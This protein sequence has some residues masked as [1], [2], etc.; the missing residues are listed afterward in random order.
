MFYLWEFPNRITGTANRPFLIVCGKFFYDLFCNWLSRSCSQAKDTLVVHLCVDLTC[1]S[2]GLTISLSVTGCW[3]FFAKKYLCLSKKVFAQIGAH[4]SSPETAMASLGL[5]YKC[6][7][8]RIDEFLPV[9]VSVAENYALKVVFR[10]VP[11]SM[12][13]FPRQN[14]VCF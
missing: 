8:P 9:F 4:N 1:S 7:S 13:R 2:K 6:F 12:Q 10:S 5:V 14:H 11:D 3:W